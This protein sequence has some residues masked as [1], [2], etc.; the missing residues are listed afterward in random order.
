MG[1]I[2]CLAGNV[3]GGHALLGTMRLL[4]HYCGIK[5]I[6]IKYRMDFEKKFRYYYLNYERDIGFGLVFHIPT[7]LTERS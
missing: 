7:L 3:S 6:C 1:A 2:G 4:H 5:K